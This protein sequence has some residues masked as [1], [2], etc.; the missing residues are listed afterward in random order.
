MKNMNKKSINLGFKILSILAF[1][2]IFMPFSRVNASPTPTYV[3][4]HYNADGSYTF[5]DFIW[6]DSSS[7]NTS[8]NN[9]PTAGTNNVVNSTTSANQT[10]NATNDNGSDESKSDLASNAIFGSDGVLPSGLVSWILLGIMILI[11]V[12]LTRKVFGAEK[13]YHETPMKHA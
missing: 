3:Y 2:L 8:T 9:S 13:N 11:I 10:N 1:G 12:I 7:A 5:G 6:G 4:G